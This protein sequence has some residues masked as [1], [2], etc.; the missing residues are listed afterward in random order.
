MGAY[1]AY[2]S[3]ILGHFDGYMPMGTAGRAFYDVFG[4]TGRPCFRF[5]YEPD[6]SQLARSTPEELE[7]FKAR[8]GLDPRRRHFLCSSRLV[9]VKR[10]EDVIA[11]FQRIAA[12]RREWDLVIAGDGPLRDRLRSSVAAPFSARIKFLGFLQME[13]LR[14]AYGCMDALVHASAREPW[15]LVINE[16]VGASLPVISTDVTGAAVELV[17]DRVN[18]RLVRPGSVAELAEAMSWLC[19]LPD[20]TPLREASARLL[21]EWRM[22]ADPVEGFAA[23]VR[24][25]SARD[26]RTL[27]PSSG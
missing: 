2:R 12:D 8:H 21:G 15:A 17:R 9:P 1:R 18:G 27:A 10:V 19:G 14:C 7:S 24:H 11:A 23:A 5:P 26:G 25:F 16:A 6:Y 3:W 4:R 13:E 20:L 22:Q